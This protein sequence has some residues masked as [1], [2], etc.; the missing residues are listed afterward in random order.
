MTS[1]S[2]N[3]H[4]QRTISSKRTLLLTLDAF[5]TLFHPRQPVA[6]QY[7]SVAHSFGLPAS[8]VTSEKV[9]HAF[10]QAF[11]AQLTRRPN[12]GREDVLR[13]QYGG[14]RQWWE[15]VIRASFAQ[16]LDD[17][18]NG[19]D[20]SQAH[21]QRRRWPTDSSIVE[22]VRPHLPCGM[23]EYLLNRFAS[24]DGYTLYED[25]V[26]F[27]SMLRKARN[28]IPEDR[29]ALTSGS[30]YTEIL[31]G[32]I[33]NSDDRVP[34]VLKSL[35]LRV[36]NLRADQGPRSMDLPGFEQR[37]SATKPLIV[38][39]LNTGAAAAA[40]SGYYGD[41]DGEVDRM[42]D[43]VYS[44]ANDIDM[45]ITSYE[46]GEEKP[47]RVI[48]DVAKRQAGRLLMPG[49]EASSAPIIQ[50]ELT[51]VHVGDDI[52]KDYHA[53]INAGWQSY[54][55]PR[56][57]LRKEDVAAFRQGDVRTIKSLMDLVEILDLNRQL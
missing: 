18:E 14:P 35:G 32:V 1:T 3:R 5:G 26:P 57:T 38:P 42:S 29:D 23:V 6:E 47:S 10:K 24:K 41:D 44:P 52:R 54:F 40:T 49:S 51:C 4:L 50:G 22:G 34:A 9:E 15:E 17:G 28:T 2:V 30:A 36:G 37:N 46:A 21:E 11:K 19:A 43:Y 27:F 7:A 13:G 39:G 53:A 33:S 56:D 8:L 48:F 12:Y 20:A 25:V 31:L 55:L 16:I 45:I